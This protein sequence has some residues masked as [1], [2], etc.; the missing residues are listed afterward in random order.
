MGQLIA[1]LQLGHDDGTRGHGVDGCER[2]T[3]CSSAWF[4]TL[5]AKASVLDTLHW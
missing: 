5:P 1:E 4:H 3:H 2:V